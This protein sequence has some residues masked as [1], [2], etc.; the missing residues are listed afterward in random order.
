MRRLSALTL[1]TSLVLL[2]GGCASSGIMTSSNITSVDLGSADYE[3]VATGVAGSA[4]AHYI[5]GVSAPYWFQAQAVAVAR[6]GGS[7][8]LYQDALQ[9]LWNTFEEAHGPVEGRRLALINVRQDFDGLNLVL[10]TRPTLSITADVVE[11]S[12]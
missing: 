6:V 1:A 9:D 8:F 12:R 5:L 4:T 10:Y 2:L 7:Q 3:I 11:F